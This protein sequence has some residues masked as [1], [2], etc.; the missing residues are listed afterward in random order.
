MGAGHGSLVN[1]LF[2]AVEYII[3]SLSARLYQGA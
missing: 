3:E 1:S 2:A